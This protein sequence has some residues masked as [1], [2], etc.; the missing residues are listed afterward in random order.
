MGEV[1]KKK[2]GIFIAIF[3]NFKTLMLAFLF[4]GAME[5]LHAQSAVN[6]MKLPP[7]DTSQYGSFRFRLEGWADTTARHGFQ[8]VANLPVG[9]PLVFFLSTSGALLAFADTAMAQ[10]L[11]VEKR[12]GYPFHSWRRG[13]F[14]EVRIWK[15]VGHAGFARCQ[16]FLINGNRTLDE[17]FVCMPKANQQLPNFRLRQV[18]AFAW[19]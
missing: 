12:N 5:S 14:Y 3:L 2:K 15:D 11:P 18:G 4:L 6:Q 9:G 10:P 17:V 8:F 19:K 13:E 7:A 16:W 1:L